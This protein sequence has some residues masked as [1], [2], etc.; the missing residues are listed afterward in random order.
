VQLYTGAQINFGDLTPY[1]TYGVGASLRFKIKNMA[2]LMIC[3]RKKNYRN[4]WQES[5]VT[6]YPEQE[7]YFLGCRDS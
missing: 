7:K 6:K 3:S 4:F 2:F 5:L 1:L